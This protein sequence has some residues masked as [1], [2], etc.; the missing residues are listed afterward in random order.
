[1]SDSYLEKFCKLAQENK[2]AGIVISTAFMPY[3][4]KRPSVE[5]IKRIKKYS[6]N[7]I[8]VIAA[9]TYKSLEDINDALDAGADLVMVNEADNII[10]A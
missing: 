3:D 6:G 10:E 1:M 2:I 4:V 9:G 7:K 5:D 8:E